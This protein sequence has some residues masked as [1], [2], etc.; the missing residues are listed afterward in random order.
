MTAIDLS[1]SPNSGPEPEPVLPEAGSRGALLNAAAIFTLDA[2]GCIA[3]LDAAQ[4]H[5]FGRPREEWLGESWMAICSDEDKARV[6]A[7]AFGGGSGRIIVGFRSVEGG[8][9]SGRMGNILYSPLESGG[10]LWTV[11]RV[12]EGVFPPLDIGDLRALLGHCRHAVLGHLAAASISAQ[13]LSER[14]VSAA[15]VSSHDPCAKI[16][17]NLLLL[18]EAVEDCAHLAEGI[19]AVSSQRSAT[20]ELCDLLAGSSGLLSGEGRA[21]VVPGE[22]T[23][24]IAEA[25]LHAGAQSGPLRRLL[26]RLLRLCGRYAPAPGSCRIEA[27]CDGPFVQLVVSGPELRIPE[28]VAAIL[29][30]PLSLHGTERRE[31]SHYFDAFVIGL[32]SRELGARMEVGECFASGAS[33]V[34][35]TLALQPTNMP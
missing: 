4:S 14:L 16:H 6:S 20:D 13:I 2:A 22:G 26:R 11:Q 19:L 1:E 31:T 30:E 27:S 10:W 32:L 5:P 15:D 24:A 18:E 23:A 35:V 7:E 21:P 29:N 9:D 17:H 3:S 25:S 8:S 34:T 28:A 12:T 33:K